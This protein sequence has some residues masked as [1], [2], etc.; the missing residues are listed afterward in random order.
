MHHPPPA[1]PA[2]PVIL[3]HNRSLVLFYICTKHHQ[4][5]PKGIHVTEQRQEIKFKHK[6]RR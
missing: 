4:N 5:I 2:R 3:V 1:N 6:K